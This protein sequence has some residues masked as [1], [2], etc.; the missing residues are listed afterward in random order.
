MT[1]IHFK[2]LF[3][4]YIEAVVQRCSVIKL[5]LNI[6]QNLQENNCARVTFLINFIKEETLAQMSYCELCEIFKNTFYTEHHR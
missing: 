5:F 2:R 3:S 1:S 4:Y 6:S